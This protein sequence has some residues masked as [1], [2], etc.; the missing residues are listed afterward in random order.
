MSEFEKHTIDYAKKIAVGSFIIGSIIFLT[1]LFLSIEILAYLGVIFVSF[2]IIANGIILLQLIYLWISEKNKRAEI[3]NIIILV[4]TN[5][6]I[7]LIYLKIGGNL[8]RNR[9]GW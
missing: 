7:A 1:F 9:F 8:F 3:R 5:I 2:A 4:L 6:P